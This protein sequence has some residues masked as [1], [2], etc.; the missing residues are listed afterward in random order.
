MSAG[1]L[2]ALQ[3]IVPG[4]WISPIMDLCEKYGI[5]EIK[6]GKDHYFEGTAGMFHREKATITIDNTSD[7][8]LLAASIKKNFGI[9][10]DLEEAGVVIILHE[11]GH[12][13]GRKCNIVL[14]AMNPGLF[15]ERERAADEWAISQFTAMKRKMESDY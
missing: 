7:R 4:K 9:S 1:S 3:T 10:V 13:Q 12:S 15:N 5:K 8:A 2:A 11:I 14:Q 6:L